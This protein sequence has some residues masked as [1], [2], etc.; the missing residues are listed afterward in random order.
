M[1]YPFALHPERGLGT[2]SAGRFVC[3]RE[4][5]NEREGDTPDRVDRGQFHDR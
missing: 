5:G 1:Q 4:S 3:E 2:H